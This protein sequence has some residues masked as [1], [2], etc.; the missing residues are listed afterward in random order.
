M[1]RCVGVT[2]IYLWLFF[3]VDIRVVEGFLCSGYRDICVVVDI[4]INPAP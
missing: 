2:I 4:H 3:F 1:S